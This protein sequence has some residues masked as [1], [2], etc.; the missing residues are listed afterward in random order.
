[1]ITY[2]YKYYSRDAKVP[3]HVSPEEFEVLKEEL[4]KDLNKGL[5]VFAVAADSDGNLVFCEGTPIITDAFK[6]LIK[7]IKEPV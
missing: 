5:I 1:M 6:N 2:F 7:L 3:R 4:T